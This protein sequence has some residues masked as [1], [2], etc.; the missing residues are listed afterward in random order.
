MGAVEAR[1]GSYVA[2]GELG[3]TDGGR[4]DRVCSPRS[5]LGARARPVVPGQGR[6]GLGRD[7]EVLAAPDMIALLNIPGRPAVA[8]AQGEASRT[9]GPERGPGEGQE[10]TRR[11]IA[12]AGGQF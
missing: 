2:V 3:S 4:L 7:V 10:I 6:G 11:A 12:A 8:A 5:S 9:P 1:H